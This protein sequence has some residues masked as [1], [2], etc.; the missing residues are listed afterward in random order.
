MKKRMQRMLG[1]IVAGVM[2]SAGTA[3]A[4]PALPTTFELDLDNWTR[5]Y[6]DGVAVPEGTAPLL[7]YE[8]QAFL[9]FND[10]SPTA[11]YGGGD[12]PPTWI[13][14][15][16]DGTYLQGVERNVVI[17]QITVDVLGNTRIYFDHVTDD[18]SNPNYWEVE[19]WNTL[20]DYDT[21]TS[22]DGGS[23]LGLGPNQFDTIYNNLTTAAGSELFLQ[24]RFA[25]STYYDVGLDLSGDGDINFS[26]DSYVNA[27]VG[28]ELPFSLLG[29]QWMDQITNP[30]G[31]SV[32]AFIDVNLL[33]GVGPLIVDGI[34]GDP[35][36]DLAIQNVRLFSELERNVNIGVTEGNWIISDDGVRGGV[37]PEP[38]TFILLGAGLVG[39]ATVVR[40]R[41]K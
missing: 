26:P 10:I 18:P 39:L 25:D 15:T 24:G 9:N 21:F 32:N 7:G 27:V 3:F 34:Y 28:I 41:K 14:G 17:S 12:G 20:I 33:A 1:L 23:Y 22:S 30:F 35:S 29:G 2:L 4:F 11:G 13:A 37:V 38:S 6:D 40:K 19:L 36:Y 8:S 31:L 5:L 16:T